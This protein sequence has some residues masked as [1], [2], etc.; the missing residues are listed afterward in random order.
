MDEDQ[1]GGGW[2]F[3]KPLIA[4]IANDYESSSFAWLATE[5]AVLYPDKNFLFVEVLHDNPV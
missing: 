1:D 3:S 2:L 4:A 5:V